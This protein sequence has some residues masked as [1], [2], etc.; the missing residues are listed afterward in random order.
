MWQALFKQ[1][2]QAILPTLFKLVLD[3]L[4][5]QQQGQPA[6]GS[7]MNFLSHYTDD[8]IKAACDDAADQ[9]VK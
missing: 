5:K 3:G 8:Q 6:A 2:L 1:A 9:L 7:T 4:A